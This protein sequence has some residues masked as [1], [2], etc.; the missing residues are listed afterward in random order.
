[1][2]VAIL[3]ITQPRNTVVDYTFPNRI[4]IITW[5]SKK[6]GKIPPYRNIM[7]AMD[8]GC[9]LFYFISYVCISIALIIAVKVS[10]CY[11]VTVIIFHCLVVFKVGKTYGVKNVD[12]TLAAMTPFAML[13]AEGMPGW[14][15]FESK[16]GWKNVQLIKRGR[17]GNLLLLTWS[18][19]GM[20]LMFG[21][22]CNLRA[23]LLKAK[24]LPPLDTAESIFESGKIVN[25]WGTSWYP[26]F[27]RYR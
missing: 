8:T 12:A 11:I 25:I 9:W 26:D 5:C 18:V 19:M 16:K 7:M 24:L 17:A 21:F 27:L 6:P 20:I 1:M 22:T 2:A 15:E 14:F 10:V 23:I 3:S 13:N 4:G